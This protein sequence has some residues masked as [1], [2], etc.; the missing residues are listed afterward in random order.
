MKKLVW[1]ALPLLGGAVFT[2]PG[3][4]SF[5]PQYDYDCGRRTKRY[6]CDTDDSCR[7]RFDDHWVCLATGRDPAQK[8]CIRVCPE[9]Y[10]CASD[11]HCKAASQACAET[12]IQCG[13]RCVPPDKFED[14]ANLCC[15]PV[16]GVDT[17]CCA[18]R[19]DA[20]KQPVAGEFICVDTASDVAHC[21]GCN[22]PCP[23]N[24]ACLEGGCGGDCRNDSDC[25]GSA[26]GPDCCDNLCT[27]LHTDPE[28][29]NTCGRVC[30]SGLRCL[31][32][33][34]GT[35]VSDDCCGPSCAN[36]TTSGSG[37]VGN[38]PAFAHC[39][40]VLFSSTERCA[41]GYS[42]HPPDNGVNRDGQCRRISSTVL[43]PF[44]TC[45]ASTTRND[46]GD[47]S[48][49]TSASGGTFIYEHPNV[50]MKYCRSQYDCWPGT[51][52]AVLWF[53]SASPAFGY[54]VLDCPCQHASYPHMSTCL[55]Q[56]DSVVGYCAH[57]CAPSGALAIG[58]DCSSGACV[59]GG[60]CIYLRQESTDIYDPRCLASCSEDAG[61]DGGSGCEAGQQCKRSANDC[62]GGAVCVAP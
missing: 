24:E 19:Y 55:G 1:L 33:A 57:F 23:A 37:C 58:A 2:I 7:K 42:C 53:D 36:C 20:E 39:G 4:C 31:N 48:V 22:Q 13:D 60:N 29:C 28:N 43:P 18:A 44:T 56:H 50:C 16:C 9:N 10:T 38:D 5:N 35:G 12:E 45:T 41:S 32:G 6:V 3:P 34:C 21:G 61:V 40:C 52:C 27:D 25:A 8:H 30:S 11:G 46:C 62:S 54:C 14:Y 51:N 59:A 49:C 47:G 26:Y 17:Q 15:S